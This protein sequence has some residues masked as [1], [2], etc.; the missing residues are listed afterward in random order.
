MDNIA[1]DNYIKILKD[2]VK[3]VKIRDYS[4]DSQETISKWFVVENNNYFLKTQGTTVLFWEIKDVEPD[5]YSNIL[6][7]LRNKAEIIL[8]L[9]SITNGKERV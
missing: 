7:R 3:D 2:F 8:H 6:Q 1:P 4:K 5:D 9:H